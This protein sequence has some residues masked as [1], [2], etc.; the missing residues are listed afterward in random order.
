M[1]IHAWL[2]EREIRGLRRAFRGRITRPQSDLAIGVQSPQEVYD[3]LD[4]IFHDAGLD[5]GSYGV[6]D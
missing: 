4:R 5:D 6:D 3:A 1:L 2:E